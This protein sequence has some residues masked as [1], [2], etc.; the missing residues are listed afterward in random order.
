MILNRLSRII[1]IGFIPLTLCFCEKQ[2]EYDS[3]VKITVENFSGYNL[4]SLSIQYRTRVTNGYDWEDIVF[5]NIESGAIS[6]LHE[7]M[8]LNFELFFRAYLD[9][10]SIS[11]SWVCPYKAIDP[12]FYAIPSG[13]YN[14]GIL[15]CDTVQSTMVIGLTIYD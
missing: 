8:N 12:T 5:Y 7:A 3:R 11:E 1:I 2:D 6:E 10:D 15:E 13:Y 9:G 4:D 14:F